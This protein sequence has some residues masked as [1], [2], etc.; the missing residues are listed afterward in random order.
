MINK[1]RKETTTSRSLPP[2]SKPIPQK[3]NY[4]YAS[5]EPLGQVIAKAIP[6]QFIPTKRFNTIFEGIFILV[7]II[8]LLQLPFSSLLAGNTD[9]SIKVGY[10]L[11]FLELE[12]VEVE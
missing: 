3:I 2:I 7:L 12:L 11:T 4:K 5:K 6:K 10:P 1:K 9:V 8:S